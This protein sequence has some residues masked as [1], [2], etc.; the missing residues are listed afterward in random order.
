[1]PIEDAKSPHRF[2]TISI[3]CGV[4]S[5]KPGWIPS[6]LTEGADQALHAA[7]HKGRSCT[8]SQMVEGF[9]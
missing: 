7:K 4:A 6:R 5:P 1:M 3:G 8:E 2:V 9:E